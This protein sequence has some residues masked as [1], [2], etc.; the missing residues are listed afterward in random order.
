L[1]RGSIL[2]TVSQIMERTRGEIITFA[3]AAFGVWAFVWGI[4]LV[5]KV[6]VA[7]A[8]AIVLGSLFAFALRDD[9]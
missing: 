5:S 1:N 4:I 3:T 6:L 2:A 8:A 7:C 9:S